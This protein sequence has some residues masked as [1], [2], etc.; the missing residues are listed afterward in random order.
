MFLKY[1][2]YIFILMFLF[3][4]C[5]FNNQ[6]Q[7]ISL[8]TVDNIQINSASLQKTLQENKTSS[9]QIKPAIDKK[10]YAFYKEW[11]GVKYKLGG[12]SKSGIDCSAFIQKA[13]KEKL[14]LNLPRTTKLQSKVGK[15]IN[16]SQ[17]NSGDL[18]FFKTGRTSRHVGIYMNEGN[19]MHASTKRGVTI[20]KLDNVYFKRHYWK[21]TRVID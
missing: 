5:S 7:T 9:L 14:D 20:S 18:V 15:T 11:K 3:T 1:L 17:L 10:L 2:A 21:A 4:G 16:K 8:I 12:N 13:F 19:F 6:V